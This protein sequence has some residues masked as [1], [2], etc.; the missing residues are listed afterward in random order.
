MPAPRDRPILCLDFDGVLHAYTSGW[1]GEGKAA[2]GPVEGAMQF[3]IDAT[4]EF[5]IAIYSTRS[6]SHEGRTAMQ[7]FMRYW[8]TEAGAG[9]HV[10]DL[11]EWPET[12][13]PAMVTIDDR[14]IT[15]T[16]TFPAIKELLAFQPWN[17]GGNLCKPTISPSQ[18]STEPNSPLRRFFTSPSETSKTRT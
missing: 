18:P 13:P 14:A 9:W 6:H 15:F 1:Q 10:F 7:T 16:G 17:K 2:D 11:L 8:L 5:R 4:P 12:K 3:V